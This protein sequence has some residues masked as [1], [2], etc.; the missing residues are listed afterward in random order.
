MLLP[1][2]HNSPNF[3]GF[4]D[5]DFEI[6]LNKLHKLFNHLGEF[7]IEVVYSDS[8]KDFFLRICYNQKDYDIYFAEY[9]KSRYYMPNT[10]KIYVVLLSESAFIDYQVLFNTKKTF[11][12]TANE[13]I[14]ELNFLYYYAYGFQ[15][16][17]RTPS[18]NNKL[19]QY[20]Y[21]MKTNAYRY[22]VNLQRKNKKS[23]RICLDFFIHRDSEIFQEQIYI[24]DFNDIKCYI[25]ESSVALFKNSFIEKKILSKLDIDKKD[26]LL[27][28][29]NILSILDI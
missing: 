20:D 6:R 18:N 16:D 14:N 11:L 7:S 12:E 1:L 2:D 10:I 13:T 25:C 21:L 27:S 23:I 15:F 17:M 28:H 3:K 24:Q 5:S 9:F 4:I 19:H 26:L 29:T 22:D 8:L